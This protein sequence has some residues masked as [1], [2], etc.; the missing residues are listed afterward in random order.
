MSRDLD[1]RLNDR[2]QAAVQEWLNSKKEFHIM[3][4]HPMHGWPILG[5]LWGCKMTDVT[6]SQWKNT[7]SKVFSI[8]PI[9]KLVLANR[10]EK[11][12][13]QKFLQK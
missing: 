10:S 11:G 2:E 1:S 3:R 4:D 5:G 12:H 7:W 6:R 9:Y 13:D 8:F